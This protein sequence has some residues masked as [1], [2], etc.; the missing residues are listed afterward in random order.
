MN[1]KAA[2]MAITTFVSVS[3]AFAHGNED[4]PAAARTFDASKVQDTAFGREGDPAKATRTMGVDLADTMRFSPS[5]IT[6]KR[7]ET[8]KI[9]AT[10]RGRLLHEIVIGTPDELSKHA[11]MMRK[12][13]GMEHDAPYMAHVKP[14]GRGEVVWQFTKAGEFQFACLVPGHFEAGMVGKV[15]VK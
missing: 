15:T 9:V 1:I 8:V 4:H 7:G 12:F 2:F 10:N 6:V 3:G 14:G 13:P 5:A 11:D